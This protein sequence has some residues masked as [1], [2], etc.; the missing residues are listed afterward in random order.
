MFYKYFLQILGYGSIADICKNLFMGEQRTWNLN[1]NKVFM[2][3]AALSIKFQI[4]Q[5]KIENW[6]FRSQNELISIIKTSNQIK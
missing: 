2:I 1:I 3:N 5:L 6:H 4:A